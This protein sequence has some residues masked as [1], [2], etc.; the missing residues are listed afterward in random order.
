MTEAIIFYL[1]GSLA[2]VGAFF[3]VVRRNPVSSAVSLVLT[4]FS[5]AVLFLT[6]Q[7]SLVAILQIMVYA[8]AIMVLFLFVIMLLNLSDDSLQQIRPLAP[9]ALLGMG[10]SGFIA[11]VLISGFTGGHFSFPSVDESFG[12]VSEVAK[13]LFTKYLLPF[14]VTSILLLVAIIGAVLLAKKD[15]TLGGEDG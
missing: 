9:K 15:V 10:M 7:A 11:F 4:L 1:F 14:E 3:M 13:L 8:G 12:T 2:L 5:V 6:L